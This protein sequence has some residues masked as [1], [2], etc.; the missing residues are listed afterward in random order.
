MISQKSRFLKTYKIMP[1]HISTLFSR[2]MS[3]FKLYFFLLPSIATSP[4]IA[5]T[6]VAIVGNSSIDAEELSKTV[7]IPLIRAE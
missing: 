5:A 3:S 1:F 4:R 7:N 6:R 2:S